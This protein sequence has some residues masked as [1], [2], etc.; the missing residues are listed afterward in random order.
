MDS[1]ARQSHPCGPDGQ[2][3][4]RCLER[5]VRTHTVALCR[6]AAGHDIPV[7]AVA[8]QI[9]IARQTL[10]DWNHL[11][12]EHHHLNPA[13]RGRPPAPLE[14]ALSEQVDELLEERRG[15]LGLP[16]LKE[17]F[18]QIPRITLK[19]LRDHYRQE[20][21]PLL[22]HL[23]WTRPGTVWSADFTEP[24]APIDGIYPYI[25]CIR[26]LASSRQL[27]AWPV[28]HPAADMT[29]KA[30]RHLFAIYDPPLVLKTDNGSHFIASEVR[31]LLAAAKVTHLLSPPVTPRYN[32]AQEASIGSLKTRALHIAAAA[33]RF[34]C[35]SCDD[36]EAARLEANSQGRPQG[37]NGPVPDELWE[38]RPPI[39]QQ[40]RDQFICAVALAGELEQQ[41]FSESIQQQPGLR[42][43]AALTAPQRATVA[44]RAIRRALVDLGFLLARR[45]MN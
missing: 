28:L 25:L 10:D 18:P 2:K 11:R 39:F 20:H 30:L 45:T 23:I 4:L 16:A 29:V 19:H 21:E 40:Q 32:G 1:V 44:R 31:D 36:V 7:V 9:G 34:G 43:A 8:E 35:W 14:A 24:P 15:R 5:T 22:E 42:P 38:T 33:G 13:P 27:L 37:I 12:Q 17:L 6:W 3:P 26:D 41:K